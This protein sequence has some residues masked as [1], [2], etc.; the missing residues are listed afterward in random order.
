MN[1]YFWAVLSTLVVVVGVFIGGYVLGRRSAVL[2]HREGVLWGDT[3]RRGVVEPR[4]VWERRVDYPRFG[5]GDVLRVVYRDSIRVDS[6]F[7]G[8]G[9]DT[10]GVVE[11]YFAERGYHLEF[12]DDSVGVFNVDA[13]VRANRLVSADAEII[14]RVRYVSDIVE[15]KMPLFRPWFMMDVGFDGRSYG[16]TLGVDVGKRYKVGLGG[17]MTDGGTLSGRLVLGVNF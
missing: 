3:L 10:V 1:R 2:V 14:P 9:I 13:V 16:G 15:V 6:V 8:G 12:G 7:V 17:V 4:L 5:G 11:D